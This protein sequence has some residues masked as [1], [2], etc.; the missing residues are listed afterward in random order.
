[1][2]I[3]ST[4]SERLSKWSFARANRR[5]LKLLLSDGAV[6]TPPIEVTGAKRAWRYDVEFGDG[7][8][9][10]N[11][12]LAVLPPY[13]EAEEHWIELA[14][15]LLH[16]MFGPGARG[17][18]SEKGCTGY[19]E[20]TQRF[21]GELKT[22]IVGVTPVQL[23]AYLMD[24]ECSSHVTGLSTWQERSEHKRFGEARSTSRA[25]NHVCVQSRLEMACGV[26]DLAFA[27]VVLAKKVAER[28]LTYVWVMAPIEAASP[29]TEAAAGQV[30]AGEDPARPVGAEPDPSR[31]R[32]QSRRMS[33][34]HGA[35]PQAMRCCRLTSIGE[36]GG[37]SVTKLEYAGW[38]ELRGLTIPDWIRLSVIVPDQLRLPHALLR[39]FDG[40]FI[41]SRLGDIAFG[42][43]R[44]DR[45]AAV[46]EFVMETSLLRECV[47]R[48]L[49]ALLRALVMAENN[50]TVVSRL[51]LY[52]NASRRA[53]ARDLSTITEEEAVAMGFQFQLI[54]FSAST[55]A[56]ALY[57]FFNRYP[58]LR[59]FDAFC[60]WFQPLMEVLAKRLMVTSR[61]GMSLRVTVGALLGLLDV[62]SDLYM[63][64]S[65]WST[66]HNAAAI[67]TLV[68]VMTSILL[69]IMIVFIQTRHCGWRKVAHE[70]AIVLSFFKPLIDAY[71]VTTGDPGDPLAALTPA[72][73]LMACRVSEM[74]GEAIPVS[75]LQL[76]TYLAMDEDNRQLAAL[77]SILLSCMAT[78]F[79]T[80]CIAYDL[81]TDSNK[82]RMNSYFFGWIQPT[83][84]DRATTFVL[85]T[86]FHAG[87]VLGKG[88]HVRAYAC[89]RACVRARAFVSV[90]VS[91]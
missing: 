72:Q 23:A 17:A 5:R 57:T 46:S 39:N 3:S 69:Q 16:E 71:R 37:K 9:P 86:T 68:M 28:P 6:S 41:G 22:L 12:S 19:D 10:E 55:P 66:G 27:N 73:E 25:D 21:H 13:T 80:A 59:E 34:H 74:V 33:V 44:Q 49:G 77:A 42:T 91:L 15:E 14:E 65:L 62:G 67:G 56:D 84:S 4:V 43:A 83:P 60:P 58:F 2:Q 38:L 35:P 89:V 24:V 79:T 50:V 32:R 85:L 8:E 20:S 63:I 82:R 29:I 81:D 36:S 64:L 78:A 18:V 61:I 11:V 45:A 88:V 76:A 90:C 31:R 53:S 26:P 75:V 1:V 30:P 7:P 87:V 40:A 48:Y 70:V 54:L 51:S 47:F 52:T